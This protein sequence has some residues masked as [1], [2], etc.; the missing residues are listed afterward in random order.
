MDNLVYLTLLYRLVFH[1]IFS[2]QIRNETNKILKCDDT[3]ITLRS[4]KNISKRT[5]YAK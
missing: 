2:F 1:L 4:K 5:I 3:C